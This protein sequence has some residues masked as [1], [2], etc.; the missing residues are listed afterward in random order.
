[1]LEL[2]AG[3]AFGSGSHPSTRLA[4]AALDELM[5]GGEVVADI[6]C[7]SGV[8]AVGAVLLGAARAVAVDIEPVARAVTAANALRNGVADRVTVAGATI[9]DLAEAVD[10][11][12]AN[13]GAAALTA[14]ASDLEALAPL[15]VLS[16]LLAD[17][18]GPVAA[19]F[20]RCTATVSAPI[21][22]WVA[23]VLRRNHSR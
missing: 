9:H 2:D 14:I 13:I 19:G 3:R 18:A 21:D 5:Q 23:L 1:V 8:L 15:I 11:A 20:E 10:I 22:G 7:G 16:G 12:V 17:Q 4:L 6:G